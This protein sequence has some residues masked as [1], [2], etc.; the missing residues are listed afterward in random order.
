VHHSR[1]ALR[2]FFRLRSFFPLRHFRLPLSNVNSMNHFSDLFSDSL[3]EVPSIR[4]AASKEDGF[5]RAG[6]WLPWGP[7][8]F[9]PVPS[10]ARY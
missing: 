7:F 8:P 6:C 3:S 5:L 1:A 2:F 10:R 4:A 9:P